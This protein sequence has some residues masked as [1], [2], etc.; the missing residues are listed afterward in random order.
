M[1]LVSVR[2]LTVHGCLALTIVMQTFLVY[3]VYWSSNRRLM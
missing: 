3:F 1:C 2:G